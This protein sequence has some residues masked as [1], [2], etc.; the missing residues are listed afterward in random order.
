MCRHVVQGVRTSISR[1]MQLQLHRVAHTSC[2]SGV[3]RD[4]VVF[5]PTCRLTPH[6][7][8]TR[9]HGA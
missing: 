4:H 7:Q 8:A 9:I 1:D 3:A 5:E 6:G 2:G